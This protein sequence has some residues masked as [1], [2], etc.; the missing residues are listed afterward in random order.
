MSSKAVSLHRRSIFST[1]EARLSSDCA[2]VIKSLRKEKADVRKDEV[3]IQ[4]GIDKIRKEIHRFRNERS[5]IK[6]IL[7]ANETIAHKSNEELDTLY[8]T[9]ATTYQETWLKIFTEPLDTL[10]T[11]EAIRD[12]MRELKSEVEDIKYKASL[13]KRLDTL[14]KGIPYLEK[15]IIPLEGALQAEKKRI[16]PVIE[17]ITKDVEYAWE[18]NKYCIKTTTL[19]SMRCAGATIRQ[20]HDCKW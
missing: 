20:L 12:I 18:H 2:E 6:K 14:D 10:G 13:R 16:A 11:W 19:S 17:S 8:T 3:S 1:V 5:S 7:G 15:K 9:L 4:K